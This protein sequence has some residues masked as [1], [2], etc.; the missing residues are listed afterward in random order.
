M[1]TTLGAAQEKYTPNLAWGL[2]SVTPFHT[3]DMENLQATCPTPLCP[4]HPW[5]VCVFVCF[6]VYVLSVYVNVP[7]GECTRAYVYVLYVYLNVPMGV[8]T[9]SQRTMPD[10]FL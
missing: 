2:I 3:L 5:Y 1:N 9:Y 8:C 4:P 7:L 10:Y 6:C